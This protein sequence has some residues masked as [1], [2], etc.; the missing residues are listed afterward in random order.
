[1]R[2]IASVTKCIKLSLVYTLA[3]LTNTH[4]HTQRAQSSGGVGGG[5]KINYKIHH[6][7]AQEKWE[8]WEILI[9]CTPTGENSFTSSS[10]KSAKR[11]RKKALLEYSAAFPFP[12]KHHLSLSTIIH[13]HHQLHWAGS[14]ADAVAA[15]THQL[16]SLLCVR[17]CARDMYNGFRFARFLKRRDGRRAPPELLL[18]I[19]CADNRESHEHAQQSTQLNSMREFAIART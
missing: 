3:A 7:V 8:V 15:E 6:C 12:V 19:E 16:C 17:K 9:Y 1:M 4:T 14:L 5:A 13:Y 18:I 10:D 2:G 11:G